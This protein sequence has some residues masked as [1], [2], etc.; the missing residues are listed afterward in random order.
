MIQSFLEWSGC[1]TMSDSFLY[2]FA[3]AF[4][5]VVLIYELI[6]KRNQYK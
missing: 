6:E 2:G 3:I 1:K 5:F 4:V